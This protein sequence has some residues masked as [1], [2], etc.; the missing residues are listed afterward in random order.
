MSLVCT[1]G[2]SLVYLIHLVCFV[3]LVSLVSLVYP[4]SLVQPDKRDKPNQPNTQDRPNRGVECLEPLT[5]SLNLTLPRWRPFRNQNREGNEQTLQ[6]MA[7]VPVSGSPEGSGG[8]DQVCIRQGPAGVSG[9]SGAQGTRANTRTPRIVGVRKAWGISIR[10]IL[11]FHRSA[12][13]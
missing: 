3:H 5:L 12:R 11:P 6:A 1:S 4:L 8:S 9:E 7:N 10:P 2:I 13:L